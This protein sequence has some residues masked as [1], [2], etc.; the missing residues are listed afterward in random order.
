M[1]R[2]ECPRL[3][4]RL[5]LGL[6]LGALTGVL[7]GAALTTLDSREPEGR[8]PMAV[9]A[10]AEPLYLAL[11][12]SVAAGVGSV[13]PS[14]DATAPGEQWREQGYPGLFADVLAEAL[15]CVPRRPL[16][17]CG[18]LR[19]VNE[20][21]PGATTASLLRDQLPVARALLR[22]R[23]GPSSPGDVP[24]V[25]LTI[26]GNDLFGPVVEACVTGGTTSSAACQEVVREGLAAF[27]PRYE[28]A[29]AGLR[30]AAGSEAVIVTTTYYNPLRA[31]DLGRP[32][33]E[34]GPLADAVL[35]GSSAPGL[36]TEGMN[37]VIRAASARHGAVVADAYGVLREPAHFVGGS[38]CLH[39]SAE[40]HR[41][42]AELVAEAW[43]S[44]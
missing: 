25:T 19:Y 20:A 30:E 12:D 22:S 41:L 10:P 32:P 27:A 28:Q 17:S 4:R 40:G 21:R 39:P 14:G 36:P 23:A 38:D 43:R 1:R 15:H 9:P 35:E 31:C 3:G 37:D 26:G 11:G 29:L 24:V 2:S 16:S 33:S 8:E 42:L 18:E 34:A 5:L 7:L 13:A 6:G 44:R